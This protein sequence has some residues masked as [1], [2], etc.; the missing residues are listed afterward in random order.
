MRYAELIENDASDDELFG[1]GALTL[2]LTP[3]Q[4]Q[5]VAQVLI[6]CCNHITK[7]PEFEELQEDDPQEYNDIIRDFNRAI[8]AFRKNDPLSA[9]AALQTNPINYDLDDWAMTIIAKK[10]GVEL[11]DIVD[12]DDP[13]IEAAFNRAQQEMRAAHTRWDGLVGESDEPS[14][15]ELFGDNANKQIGQFMH[16]FANNMRENPDTISG[17]APDDDEYEDD[18]Q[19]IIE[20]ADIVDMV[21]DAFINQGIVS[22]LKAWLNNS[23]DWWD[24]INGELYDKTGISLDDLY[25]QHDTMLESD[26][27]DEELFGSEPALTGAKRLIYN[28]GR[29]ILHSLEQAWRNPAI[30]REYNE[31]LDADDSDAMFDQVVR[32]CKLPFKQVFVVDTIIRE[33]VGMEGLNDYGHMIDH[34][35]F[36]DLVDGWQRFRDDP[37]IEHEDW[38]HREARDFTGGLR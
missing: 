30:Q 36:N 9:V 5:A 3:Q 2:G 21:A 29:R 31:Y 28:A 11:W 18:I 33:F 13:N 35:E 32:I 20:E 14:D 10:T 12:I 7:D 27:S 34:G 19:G 16:Q 23:S 37:D 25:D 15:D 17:L 6:G 26:A 22:G 1:A 8:R 4:C 38:F 24:R